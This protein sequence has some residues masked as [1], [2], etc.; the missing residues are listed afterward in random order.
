MPTSTSNQQVVSLPELRH[1]PTLRQHSS[2]VSSHIRLARPSRRRLLTARRTRRQSHIVSPQR[3]CEDST[4]LH[5]GNR[6]T[7]ADS[8]A[9]TEREKSLPGLLEAFLGR[10][11]AGVRDPALGPPRVRVGEVV[12]VVGERVVDD[13]DLGAFGEELIVDCDAA[14]LDVAG[15]VVGDRR[16]DAHGFIDAGP[17]VGA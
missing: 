11:V 7:K 6:L 5:L 14:W 15:Q 3:T 17:E 1:R 12:R 4:H 10:A 8:G 9:R 2:N 16:E 13:A